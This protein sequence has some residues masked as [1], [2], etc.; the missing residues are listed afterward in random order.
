MENTEIEKEVKAETAVELAGQ[1]W[2]D[3]KPY[4]KGIA[5]CGCIVLAAGALLKL[6]G[7]T[8]YLRYFQS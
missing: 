8:S 5:V 4:A 3:M 7:C 2:K 6:A 1:I